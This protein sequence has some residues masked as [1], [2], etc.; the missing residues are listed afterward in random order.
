MK[1]KHHK[2]DLYYQRK[3]NISLKEYKKK[4]K[5]QH[6]RCAICGRPP[7]TLPLAV[8]HWHK[9][10]KLKVKA[11]KYSTTGQ[12]KAYNT[13]FNILGYFLP[14]GKIT[15]KSSNRK[16]AV[17]AVRRKLLRKSVRGLLCWACNSGLRKWLDNPRLLRRAAKYLTYH[18]SGG[19]F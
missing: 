5:K 8:D 16:K 1:D 13:E 19:K 3:Y 9:L 14:E 11:K 18:Q 15:F 7:K 17:K 10:A 6:H 2:K 4:D 12:W